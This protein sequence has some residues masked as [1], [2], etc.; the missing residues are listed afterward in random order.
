MNQQWLIPWDWI[1]SLAE[2]I[3]RTVRRLRM[4]PG[5][6]RKE[7]WGPEGDHEREVRGQSVEGELERQCQGMAH[8]R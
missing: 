7:D 1:T 6:G 8:L 3:Q 5:K 4:E 2:S